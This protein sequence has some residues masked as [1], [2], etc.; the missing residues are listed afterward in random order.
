MVLAV[1]GWWHQNMTFHHHTCIQIAKSSGTFVVFCEKT[2]TVVA[3]DCHSKPPGNLFHHIHS[4]HLVP[5]KEWCLFPLLFFL[6][7]VLGLPWK[8]NISKQT[9]HDSQAYCIPIQIHIQHFSSCDAKF[10]YLTRSSAEKQH[11][12]KNTQ[13]LQRSTRPGTALQ[14]KSGWPKLQKYSEIC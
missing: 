4:Y 6:L 7:P 5:Q 14:T 8:N 2:S 13:G 9:S 1:L 11:D 12:M 10:I 3:T